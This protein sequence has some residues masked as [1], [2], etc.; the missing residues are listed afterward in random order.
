MANDRNVLGAGDRLCYGCGHP[1]EPGL[2][3]F[4][5]PCW[6]RLPVGVTLKFWRR[7]RRDEAG[8]LA[9][10]VEWLASHVDVPG[11]AAAGAPR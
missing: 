3:V 4:C 5:F 2:D 10:A 6:F 7:Y 9:M 1:V 11:P 8:A